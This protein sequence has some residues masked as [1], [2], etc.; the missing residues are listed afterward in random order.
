MT[1]TVDLLTKHHTHFRE[2]STVPARH[3]EQVNQ[4]LVTGF[5]ELQ[6]TCLFPLLI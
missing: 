2:V 5:P 1:S 3:L 4:K 6:E